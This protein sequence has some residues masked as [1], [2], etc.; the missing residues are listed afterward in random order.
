MLIRDVISP[1]DGLFSNM[2]DDIWGPDFDPSMLDIELFTRVGRLDTSPLADYFTTNGVLNTAGLAK[3]VH[4]RY[5]SNWKRIWDA[6]QEEYNIML[7]TSVD[8]TRTSERDTRNT[9]TRNLTGTNR[10]TVGSASSNDGSTVRTGSL[11]TSSDSETTKN[12]TDTEMRALTGSSK[13]S[14][15]EG[16]EESANERTAG[17]STLT[18]SG[19]EKVTRSEDETTT[20]DS[21]LTYAGSETTSGTDEETRGLSK[22]NTG[23]VT[24]AGSEDHTGTGSHTADVGR[25]GVGGAGVVNNTRN[26][27]AETRNFHDTRGNTRT[28]NTT[29]TDSGTVDH[30]RSEVK[31]FT[32]RSD[33]TAETGSKDVTGE[34]TKS[35][36]GRNDKTVE[37]GTKTGTSSHDTTFGKN[38]ATTDGGTVTS[39]QTGT[40]GTVVTSTDTYNSI[41]DLATGSETATRTDD[42]TSTDSG[43]I[44]NAG[45]ETLTENFHSEGSSPL[46]TFQALIQ[47][48]IEG[49]SGQGWNFTDIVIRDVQTMIASKIWR[50]HIG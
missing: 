41:K 35:F 2:P 6:L 15:T 43:T 23:T 4:Q 30:A 34:E 14:G 29:E 26:V 8:E 11:S 37:T 22:R 18:L 16:V 25:Y 38:V 12:L 13:E 47:E 44:G 40:D 36:T 27:D 48:E 49:R 42:L 45:S 17:D 10:G 19:S 3:L 20:G 28:D 46:R 33:K 31:S 7:T 9:E 50:R 39:K 24:E 21:T 5:R 32:G 1:I